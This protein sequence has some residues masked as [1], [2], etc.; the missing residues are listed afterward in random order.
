MPH[1]L[2]TQKHSACYYGME[3]YDGQENALVCCNFSLPGELWTQKHYA[4]YYG[5]EWYADQE[6]ALDVTTPVPLKENFALHKESK[7]YLRNELSPILKG[8]T[9]SECREQ[10]GI[11]ELYNKFSVLESLPSCEDCVENDCERVNC[12]HKL[13]NTHE[14]I[15]IDLFTDII[16]TVIETSTIE[17]DENYVSEDIV[18]NIF[19]D[20]ISTVIEKSTLEKED[21]YVSYTSHLSAVS[22][23]STEGNRFQKEEHFNI[24]NKSSVSESEPFVTQIQDSYSENGEDDLLT[25][26][27]TVLQGPKLSKKKKR[28]SKKKE[29]KLTETATKFRLVQQKNIPTNTTNNKNKWNKKDDKCDRNYHCTVNCIHK[30]KNK[31]KCTKGKRKIYR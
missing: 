15:V 8:A 6:N 28:V 2:W 25:N 17:D 5:M 23:V 21:K 22:T 14:N 3:W 13:N 9:K 10:F 7:Q 24:L 29:L 4:C 27:S 18:L 1:E 31:Q 11:I 30:R 20:L 12:C 16:S 19:R 26:I